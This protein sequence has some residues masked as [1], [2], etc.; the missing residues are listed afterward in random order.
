MGEPVYLRA[1]ETSD[2]DQI[3]TWHNDRN[4]YQTLT[5]P[6]H[7]VSRQT[8]LSWIERKSSFMDDE[9]NLAICI[10]GS[11]KHIGN[12]Y[13]RQIRWVERHCHLEIFI[14]E[15]AER[16][17]GFGQSAVRQLLSYAFNDLGLNRI[18]LQVLT[19]NV[20]AIRT[21]ERCGFQIEGTLRKHAF[22]QGGWKDLHV[23]GVCLD[24]HFKKSDGPR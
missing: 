24:E 6:F 12:I 10:K 22:K 5:S 19:D 15:Q 21:Y 8:V 16:S 3:H 9:V 2:L 20:A 23:M 17:K 13:L 7:F 14:G 4:L 18:H 11:D 1:L